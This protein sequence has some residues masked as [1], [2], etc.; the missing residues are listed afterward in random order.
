MEK[1]DVPFYLPGQNQFLQDY[2]KLYGLPF[3]AVFGGAPTTSPDYLPT[4]QRLM[5]R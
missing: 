1:G 4:L 2:A 5:N 3:E